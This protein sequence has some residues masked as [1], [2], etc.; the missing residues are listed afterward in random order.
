MDIELLL[1]FK[2]IEDRPELYHT[3][4]EIKTTKDTYYDVW[5]FE[6]GLDSQGAMGRRYDNNLKNW[7][8]ERNIS[9]VMYER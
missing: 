1:E 8:K 6:Y 5:G 2:I 4:F 9:R 3:V 7:C